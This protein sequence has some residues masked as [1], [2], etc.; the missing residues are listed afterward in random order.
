MLIG[1]VSFR[2]V[3][4]LTYSSQAEL[5]REINPKVLSAREFTTKAPSEPFLADVLSKPKIF[6]IGNAHELEK[7]A[8]H[9]P[10]SAN[11]RSIPA[12]S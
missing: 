4:A 10:S 12:T 5:G 8:G 6:L 2:E 9:Q 3:V 1:D 11:C 7:L